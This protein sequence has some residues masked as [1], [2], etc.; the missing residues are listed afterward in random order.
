MKIRM[1]ALAIGACAT[2]V[3]A[4]PF[5]ALSYEAGGGLAGIAGAGFSVDFGGYFASAAVGGTNVFGGPAA[6]FTAANEGEFDSHFSLDGFGPTARNRSAGPTD[7]STLTTGFYGDYPSGITGGLNYN[8]LQSGLVG[9]YGPF[10]GPGASF[11]QG[12]GSHVGDPMADG[13]LPENRARAGVAVAPP[14][15]SC[16]HFAPNA[17][18]G[19]S[20]NNGAFVGRFTI[21]TGATLTGG[22][23]FSTLASPGVPDSHDLTL[24]GPA[25]LFN[26]HNGPQFLALRAYRI[27][28]SEPVMIDNPSDVTSEGLNEGIPFGPANVF[29][30]WVQVVPAGGTFAVLAMPVCA[31]ARRRR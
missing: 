22:M 7:N 9:P 18:G 27:N 2:A 24:G 8:E 25:V 6:G 3:H 16:T 19:R 11:I 17:S 23:L 20:A 30:L 21:K 31:L 1:T 28:L 4:A 26:T 10:V 29:D 5:R 13:V 12:P 15:V 14:P